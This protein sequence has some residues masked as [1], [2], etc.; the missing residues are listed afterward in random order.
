MDEFS[1]VWTGY[2]EREKTGLLLTFPWSN[3]LDLLNGI[4]GDDKELELK[5]I[6][7]SLLLTLNL[8][9]YGNVK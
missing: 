5:K 6:K 2:W 9:F 1:L 4:G 8:R 7:N 3:R